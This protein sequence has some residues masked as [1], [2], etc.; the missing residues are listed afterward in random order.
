MRPTVKRLLFNLSHGVGVPAGF[1][2][3]QNSV[4]AYR[5]TSSGAYAIARNPQ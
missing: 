2:R 1:A 4:G 5:V 3:I